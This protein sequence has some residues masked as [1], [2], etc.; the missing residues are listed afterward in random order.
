MGDGGFLYN[1]VTQSFGVACEA[2]LPFM[3]VIFNNANYE[4]MRSNHLH[5]YPN[6]DAAASDIWHGVHI[7]GPEYSKLVDPFG[8]YGERVDDPAKL[9]QALQNGLD[10]VKQGKIS[11]ID[12][13]LSV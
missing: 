3:T 1:P 2:G 6:G 11:I 4:A 9:T 12:V 7:P 13:V 8:G 10:A 5:Y